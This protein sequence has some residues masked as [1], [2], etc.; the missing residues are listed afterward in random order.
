M[1]IL[2]LL[3]FYFNHSGLLFFFFFFCSFGDM[4]GF[5]QHHFFEDSVSGEFLPLLVHGESKT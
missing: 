5:Q 4:P 2:S 1:L 3:G